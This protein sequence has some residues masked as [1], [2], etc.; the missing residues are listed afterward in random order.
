MSQFI[1]VIRVWNGTQF[2]EAARVI[3]GG[4]A[5]WLGNLAVALR[6]FLGQGRR[7]GW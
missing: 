5:W 4:S 7:R 1:P 6:D 2:I 3:I